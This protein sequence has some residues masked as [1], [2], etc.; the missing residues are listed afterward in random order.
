MKKP[1]KGNKQ[2]KDGRAWGRNNSYQ[3]PEYQIRMRITKFKGSS[4]VTSEG[5]IS[6]VEEPIDFTKPIK[7][8]HLHRLVMQQHLGR[9]LT[10]QETVHHINGDRLDNRIKNLALFATKNQHN[11]WHACIT[12]LKKLIGASVTR[13]PSNYKPLLEELKY[14]AANKTAGMI[15]LERIML[16]GNTNG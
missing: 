5:Y 13:E 8:I 2:C 14:K 15:E 11:L 4:Y 16:Q 3:D 7:R 10:P 9:K 12:R 6:T 1:R